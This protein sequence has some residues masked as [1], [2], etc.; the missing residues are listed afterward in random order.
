MNRPKPHPAYKGNA[1]EQ[2]L[3]CLLIIPQMQ[4]DLQ[5]GRIIAMINNILQLPESPPNG[6]RK[7]LGCQMGGMG[8][9][10]VDPS[11]VALEG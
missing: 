2:D 5:A 10:G 1:L 6:I 11:R 9:A 7:L 4:H 3:G 8:K